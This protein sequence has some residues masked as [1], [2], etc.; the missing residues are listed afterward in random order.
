MPDSGSVPP[1]PGGPRDRA[2]S[3]SLRRSVSSDLL[4]R[5][6]LGDRQAA[7]E[8]VSRTAPLIR[9]R[10]RGKIARSLRTLFDSDDLLAT[11]SRRL[12]DLVR[13]KELIATSEAQLWALLARIATISVS[14]H[15]RRDLRGS[16]GNPGSPSVS[17]LPF[18]SETK[19]DPALIEPLLERCLAELEAEIDQRTL[20]MRMEDRTHAQIAASEGVTVETARKR[21]QRIRNTVRAML[22]LIGILEP[23]EGRASSTPPKPTA[24]DDHPVREDRPQL[25]MQ[26]PQDPP[27]GAGP[28]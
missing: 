22:D 8:F 2:Q 9:R 15:A 13:R 12:D 7:A 16:R 6:R 19:P 17:E 18:A 4:E 10:F 28:R 1:P 20:R 23:W 5:I 11:I 14:E 21:W 3:G 27:G 25:E 24:R 26:D